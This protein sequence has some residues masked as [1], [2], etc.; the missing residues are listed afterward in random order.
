MNHDAPPV[1]GSTGLSHQH[2][3]AIDEA[4]TWLI[5]TPPERRPRPVITHLQRQ[6]GPSACE[7]SEA[8]A[9]ARLRRA[10]AT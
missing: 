4:A 10:R 5:E 6:F 8:M 9:E 7:A 3:A 1:G 2:S